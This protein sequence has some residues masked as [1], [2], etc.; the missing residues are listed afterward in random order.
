MKHDY[1][2]IICTYC[3]FTDYGCT[4]C[5]HLT[6]NGVVFCEGAGCEEAYRDYI[7]DT[8]D[9]TDLEDLF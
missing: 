8:G 9:N 4:S 1:P 5:E 3:R 6:P 2:S 7:D